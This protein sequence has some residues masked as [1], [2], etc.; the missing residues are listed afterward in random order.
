M[1]L[2]ISWGNEIM[3]TKKLSPVSISIG[4]RWLLMICGLIGGQSLFAA[5]TFTDLP[6]AVS[7]TYTGTISLQI[8]GLTNGETVVV[9]KFL[10][11]NTNGV[12]DASDYLVQQFNLTD[13]T[14]FVIAGVT[15]FN[16]PGDL[17]ATTGAITATLNFQN[18]DFVQGIAGKF[19]YKLSSP[20]GHFSPI[21]NSF[22]VTNF[23]YAQKISGSVVNTG[24]NVPNA[25]V[26]VFP[27]GG[28]GGNG[29][30]TPV[31][32]TVANNS[33]AYT[34]QLPPGSY[35]PLAF[36]S[37][38]VANYSTS[39]SLT[40]T[41][42][43][44]ITTNLTLTNATA[45]I[46]GQFVDASNSAVKLPGIFCPV[47]TQINGQA[48]IAVCFSDTNGSFN[49]RV[50]SGQW[51][52]GNDDSALTVHGYLSYE[53]GTNVSS[54]TTGI[55]LAYPK[56]T[57]LF[58][59]RVTDTSGN[60]LVNLDFGA[61]DDN[62]NIYQAD[63]NTDTNG[64]YVL[65]VLGGLGVDDGWWVGFNGDSSTYIFS[66]PDFDENGGTNINAG[67]AVLANFTG[68]VATNFISGNVQFNG[69]PVT[70][71]NVY[72]SATINGVSFN[73]NANTDD[74]GNY[75]FNV[76]NGSWSVG[77]NCDGGDQSLDSILGSGTYQ[78]P[79][80]DNVGITNN[81]G[82]ANFNVQTSGGSSYQIFGYVMDNSGDPVTNVQVSANNG[83]GTD[84][85]TTT[86]SDG[87]YSINVGNG[88]WDVSVDCGGLTAQG[89]GC[90]NAQEINVSGNS[91]QQ[92]FTVQ[93]CSSL[94]VTTD[95]LPDGEVSFAYYNNDTSGYQLQNDG[96]NSPYT[97]SL[98]PGSLAL[99]SGMNLSAGGLLSGTPTVA[100]T[101]YFSV[102]V[103]DAGN[104][105]ADQLLSVIIYPTLVITNASPLPNG[106]LNAAYS[107]QL[108]A[109]GGWDNGGDAFGWNIFSNSLPT[110]LGI[111]LD[112]TISGTPT[113]TG[114]F[115]FG[116]TVLDNAGYSAE[117]GY[118]I[119]IL[120]PS[121]QIT[122]TSLSNATVGVTYTNQLQGS[123]GT[124]PYTWTIANGSQPLPAVLTLATNGL[125]SGVPAAGGTNNFIVRLT[126][127]NA[128]TVTH[129]FT[130]V[131]NPK[132]S[133]SAT[134]KISGTQFQFLLTGAANQ[135]YTLQ[136]STNL[137][138]AN[139]TSLFTTNSATT[140]SFLVTDPNATNGQRFYRI[141][142]GP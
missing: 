68:A 10:D 24:T 133:L 120:S 125:I 54:G 15:N 118:S 62:N 103:T 37:N 65:G 141:L 28:G 79:N 11:L 100:G 76:A 71:L 26:V 53:N 75:S 116:V 99:P 34:I 119:T 57:A 42:S 127:A 87:S 2:V 121:V 49:A 9:Q 33:G 7:N 31:G 40:L 91:V 134:A 3:K 131:V 21:T 74:N 102:R 108:G 88:T 64:N 106:T 72:A 93:T 112:G 61:Y 36:R 44:T 48:F 96:C 81:D 139:W 136:M 17:N 38:Y 1:M 115:L 20:V 52:L 8:G 107:V 13:G 98:T 23:P 73:V 69:S 114:T 51:K 12:I 35:V 123:G 59:G 97:W 16:V 25:V 126:D 122:T 138:S 39:P 132:P 66:Q 85:A 111:T 22:T 27:A 19:L 113:V 90:V 47:Q 105:T 67:Q 80:N 58:Y 56:A 95:N 110:G 55:T 32:G 142:I 84:L 5:V 70:N 41:G 78:C 135:N 46:S 137:S 50:T 101:N 140:N 117:R 43:Q 14:N 83:S 4:I 30:G 45:A 89:Y 109:A 63:V 86:G 128:L 104:N 124:T 60:P 92:N 77:V 94:Q 130:L 82:T 29:P 6:A 18:G 129:S